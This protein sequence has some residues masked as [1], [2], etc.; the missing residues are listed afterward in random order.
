V[1]SAIPRLIN[2]QAL[3]QVGAGIALAFVATLANAGCAWIMLKAARTHRSIT[4]EAD[5][6]H[7]LTDVWTTL[8]VF[9][10]VVLVHFTGWLR[11]DP[12]IAIVVAIQILWTGWTLIGRSF[13]G[14]MDRAVP[15]EDR[16]KI[17]EVLETL[18]HQGGDYHA[19]RTPDIAQEGTKQ[20]ST[21][22][23]GDAV[24]AAVAG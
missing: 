11:L 8:G 18:H 20:V 5:A 16:A 21:A 17:V 10:G 24:A 3:E 19:L 12:L 13:E 7:L 15:D 22:A 23:M 4:L 9:I 6:R 2:P 14:L 1:W